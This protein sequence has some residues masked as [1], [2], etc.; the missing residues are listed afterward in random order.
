MAINSK[1]STSSKIA[2]HHQIVAFFSPLLPIFYKFICFFHF[3]NQFYIKPIKKTSLF[4]HLKLLK[5]HFQSILILFIHD[6][7]KL[8]KTTLGF[9]KENI[10]YSFL[11][12]V[13]IPILHELLTGD[14]PQS[15]ICPNSH[16]VSDSTLTL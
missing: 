9:H 3:W 12:A 8:R 2:Y 6:M 14:N 1:I 4:S 13:F 15:L 16:P 11:L 10:E 7:S 5:S